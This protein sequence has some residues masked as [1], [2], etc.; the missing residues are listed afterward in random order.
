ML[1]PYS[2][3]RPPKSP[4]LAMVILVLVHFI[5]FGIVALV[6]WSQGSTGPVLLY[7]TAGITP[8]SMQWYQP[9][10]YSFLH[11]DVFHLS[12]NMLFLWVFG[13]NVE[14]AVGW[15]RFLGIYMLSAVLTGLL[16]AGMTRFVPGVD[17]NAPIV[18]ASGA[19]SAIIG[20]YAVRYYR[21]TIRFIGL[22]VKVPAILIL[23]LL[24]IS[25]MAMALVSLLHPYSSGLSD[26]VAHWAHIGGFI[27]G[28]VWALTGRMLQAGKHEYQAK[29]A[30]AEMKQGSP[31][32]AALRWEDVLKLQPGD[33]HVEANLAYAW[34]QA[35]DRN[36]SIV[37]Y[38]SALTG[39]LKK[40]ER[41]E[42][43][44]RY[45]EMM[46]FW[47]DLVLSA[48]LLFGIASALEDTER[49]PQAI[50][51]YKLLLDR[52]PEAGE[53]G[54]SQLRCAALMIKQ[55]EEPELAADMLADFLIDNQDG[56]L[57][58]WA[59]ELMRTAR[60]QL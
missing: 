9:F 46:G 29:D 45:L 19:I 17:L 15:K 60:K 7:A 41:S 33:C 34:A 10:T 21:S 37:H 56:E 42:S 13:G 39:L 48:P 6:L 43:A 40:G 1:L 44:I 38:T 12:V 25:E 14:D 27:I 22:P 53:S 49:I 8:S 28:M 58:A 52:W 54:I 57:T 3:D 20:I 23:A 55:G 31:A 5:I 18:G 32:A 36:Q 30:E 35:G 51:T 26:A 16:Q 4:P 47:E 11:E 24:L 59:E 50:T 2:C